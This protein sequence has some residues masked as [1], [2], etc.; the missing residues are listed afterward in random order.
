MQ[1]SSNHWPRS[2]AVVKESTVMCQIKMLLSH[3]VPAPSG[4]LILGPN[5][6]VRLYLDSALILLWPVL[7][8]R[9]QLIMMI[10]EDDRRGPPYSAHPWAPTRGTLWM[11]NPLHHT[12]HTLAWMRTH[13]KGTEIWTLSYA[14]KQHG[15]PVYQNHKKNFDHSNETPKSLA[16]LF[17]IETISELFLSKMSL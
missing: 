16:W 5:L 6:N 10:R 13:L 3:Y 14:H 8:S 4:L 15:N 9:Q 1:T 12:A 17:S 7:D 2:L 11:T